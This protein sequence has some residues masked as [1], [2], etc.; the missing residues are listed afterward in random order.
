MKPIVFY[1][2]IASFHTSLDGT[3]E[4]AR[5]FCRHHP[6]LGDNVDIRTSKIVEK[7]IGKF[8]TLNTIYIQREEVDYA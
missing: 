5:V 8:I 7:S 3:W 6:K 4:Y 2:G 1:E